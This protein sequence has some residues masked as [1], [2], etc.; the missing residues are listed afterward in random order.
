MTDW[1]TN[2]FLSKTCF[3]ISCSYYLQSKCE[4]WTFSQ[5]IR[6]LKRW[7]TKQD[8]LQ[9]NFPKEG[10]WN[11]INM[12]TWWNLTLKLCGSRVW[13]ACAMS[14]FSCRHWGNPLMNFDPWTRLPIELIPKRSAEL[15]FRWL[16]L[17]YIVTLCGRDVCVSFL[18][19]ATFC[20]SPPPEIGCR[21][22]QVSCH[23]FA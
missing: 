6:D 9:P 1:T 23:L 19:G 18:V 13:Q 2:E 7:M 4:N 17:L 3:L 12:K 22:H 14:T 20:F 10:Q 5:L 8:N 16:Q 15:S 21:P 11:F